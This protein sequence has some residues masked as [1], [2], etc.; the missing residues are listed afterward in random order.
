MLQPL[1]L[2]LI[3]ARK[4][5]PLLWCSCTCSCGCYL[6]PLIFAPAW[7]CLAPYCSCFTFTSE[8]QLFLSVWRRKLR[9]SRTARCSRP[10]WARTSTMRKCHHTPSLFA[11]QTEFVQTFEMGSPRGCVPP[12]NPASTVLV[13]RHVAAVPLTVTVDRDGLD[14]LESR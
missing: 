4:G 6:L 10:A 13:P 2:Q 11:L 3:E 1:Q 9:Q 7:T 14:A 5:A 8:A 12:I